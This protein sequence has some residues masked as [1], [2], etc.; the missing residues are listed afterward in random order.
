MAD[1]VLWGPQPHAMPVSTG[2]RAVPQ[3]L[4]ILPSLPGKEL[5]LLC[6]HFIP[7]KGRWSLSRVRKLWSFSLLMRLLARFTGADRS[8]SL[9]DIREQQTVSASSFPRFFE[10]S[11]I[12]RMKQPGMSCGQRVCISAGK[13]WV[14]AFCLLSREQIRTN[15]APAGSIGFLID[16][17]EVCRLLKKRRISVK[18][19]CNPNI[20]EKR[21]WKKN[22]QCL[23]TWNVQK[24]KMTVERCLPAILPMA[25]DC[26][27]DKP[28]TF[29]GDWQ[30]C[31]ACKP[32]RNE[33]LFQ[34][35]L[36]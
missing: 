24:F 34:H 27:E 31:L 4:Q 36:S 8:H 10:S 3:W 14:Q 21:T 2:S 18:V 19:A 25:L 20:L 11:S 16:S 32:S 29:R 17:K 15:F 7:S 22:C 12:S 30:Q 13:L 28:V 6:L 5:N 23:C 26:C 9:V 33:P 35:N 1:E